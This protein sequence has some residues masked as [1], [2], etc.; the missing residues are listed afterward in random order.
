[1]PRMKRKEL[2][3]ADRVRKE[4][5]RAK[6]R[7]YLRYKRTGPDK[8]TSIIDL[9]LLEYYAWLTKAVDALSAYLAG[10]LCEEEALSII[11]VPTKDEL[12]GD[13][14]SELTLETVAT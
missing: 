2:I 5:E 12:T 6:K 8:I 3:A 1:A 11:Y 10:E 7:Q 13:N 14:S 9:T 4:F